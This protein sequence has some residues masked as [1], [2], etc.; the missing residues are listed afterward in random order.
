[1]GHHHLYILFVVMKKNLLLAFCFVMAGSAVWAA[2]S[3]TRTA[4]PAAPQSAAAQPEAGAH[5]PAPAANVPSSSKQVKDGE[6]TEEIKGTR[7]DKM[8]VGKLDP[9]AAFNL[10]DIQNF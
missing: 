4:A 8:T 1:M 6:I 9:P 2:K 10:E 3:K 7:K 5:A